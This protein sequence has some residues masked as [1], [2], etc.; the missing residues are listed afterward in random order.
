LS[1]NARASKGRE[2]NERKNQN[3][4][5]VTNNAKLTKYARGIKIY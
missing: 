2:F 5:K 1:D 4:Y 3:L